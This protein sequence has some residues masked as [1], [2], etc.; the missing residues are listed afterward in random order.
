MSQVNFNVTKDEADIIQAIA[1]RAKTLID[2]DIDA[3][4]LMMDLTATHANGCPLDLQRLLD[5]S[6]FNFIHDIG[7]VRRHLNRKTGQLKNC[8][9]PR[10]S[11]REG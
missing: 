9:S 6:P 11:R 3:I 8:F 1:E 10:F 2:W 4:S 7:G 5:A